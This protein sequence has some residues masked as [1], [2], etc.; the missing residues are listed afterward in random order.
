M[1]PR[2]KTTALTYFILAL[3]WSF[4][5][6]HYPS[7]GSNDL[8]LQQYIQ[9]HPVGGP[10]ALFRQPVWNVS[11]QD[12]SRGGVRAGVS[13]SRCGDSSSGLGSK[14]SGSGESSRQVIQLTRQRLCPLVLAH[15]E[16]VV[17]A[18]LGQ[19][20]VVGPPLDDTM[21]VDHQ[22][23]VGLANGA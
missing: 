22:Y 17:E 2:F 23:L 19:Q 13:Q 15:I 20:L 18:A 3:G 12:K 9:E 8:G 6:I 14:P 11:S 21:V 16:I 7:L 10:D 1:I 4:L 5:F